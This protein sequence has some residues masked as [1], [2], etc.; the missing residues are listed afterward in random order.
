MVASFNV[1]TYGVNQAFRLD[2]GIWLHRKS[3]QIRH[4]FR[5]RTIVYHTCAACSELPSYISIMI[6]SMYPTEL[7]F[8]PYGYFTN[9]LHILSNK[10]TF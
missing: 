1:R 2:E 9:L 3:R 4:F 10:N 6:R 7:Y 8:K 5:K